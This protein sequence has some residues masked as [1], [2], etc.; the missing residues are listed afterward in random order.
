MLPDRR[1]ALR[2]SLSLTMLACIFVLLMIATSLLL[3]FLS[4]VMTNTVALLRI[5]A[6][7][8]DTFIFIVPAIT[9]AMLTTRY[10]AWF[11]KI[12]SMPSLK[13]VLLT[14]AVMLLSTPAMNLL[15]DWND[16][17]ILPESMNEIARSMREM[18]DAAQAS[19]KLL[20]G[21]ENVMSLI[22]AILIVGVYAGFSEEIF[23]RG[24]LQRLLGFSMN[25]HVAI[26]LAAFIFSAFHLQFF[27]FFPRMLLGAFFGYLM[28]WSG[29]LW[30]P[31]IAH[32]FN[33]SLVAFVQW[34]EETQRVKYD[35]D[36]IGVYSGSVSDIIL[37]AA[38]ICLVTM[39]IILIRKSTANVIY[40]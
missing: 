19:V 26:W 13:T 31:V 40:K 6:I 29:S 39:G 20:L 17:I 38:S 3:T 12:D 11:L 30:L 2:P 24:A 7:I 9:V 33:N 22:M 28:V 34:L 21:G 35:V 4:T 1:L 8:Q 32:V 25:R 10:P 27:G 15:V 18:E 14:I 23:F 5:G 36:A 37:V 16:N